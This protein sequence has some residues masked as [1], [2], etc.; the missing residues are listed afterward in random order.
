MEAV[1]DLQEEEVVAG[2]AARC[3][4]RRA[5]KGTRVPLVSRRRVSVPY[6]LPRLMA[7]RLCV[8]E[9]RGA[10]PGELSLDVAYVVV[11]PYL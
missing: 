5:H 10:Q 9:G 8:A 1:V 11:R 2:T 7:Y 6:G 3:Y 4:V